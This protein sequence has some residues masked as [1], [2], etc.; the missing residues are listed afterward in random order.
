MKSFLWLEGEKFPLVI[1]YEAPN[2]GRNSHNLDRIHIASRDV[3]VDPV[4]EV[5][6]GFLNVCAMGI[7]ILGR[8][9][10]AGFPAIHAR[11]KE[12]FSGHL[13]SERFRNSRAKITRP[14]HF[15]INVSV[16]TH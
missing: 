2:G 9:E 5:E 6:A 7:A 1:I 16:R 13:S 3:G 4:Q 11:A 15:S 8:Q 12:C 14:T 10:H